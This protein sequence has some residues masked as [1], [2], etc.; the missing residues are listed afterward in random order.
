M[1]TQTFIIKFFHLYYETINL[2]FQLQNFL[3]T[4]ISTDN[5]P[6]M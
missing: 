2:E 5:K 3:I 4:L 6:N 1:N